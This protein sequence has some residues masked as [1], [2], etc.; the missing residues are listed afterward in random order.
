MIE[1][2]GATPSLRGVTITRT[3]ILVMLH[4]RVAN[5]CGRRMQPWDAGW[6]GTTPSCIATPDQVMRCMYGIGALL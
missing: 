4:S 1:F 5:S 2:S 3:P 6:P